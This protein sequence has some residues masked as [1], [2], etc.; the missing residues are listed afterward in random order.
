[1]ALR[2][3]ERIST[4]TGIRSAMNEAHT[5]PDH[6]VVIRPGSSD[7]LDKVKPLWH[8]LYRHQRQHGMELSLP[9]S[10]YADWVASI[11]P[12]LGRFAT[13]MVAEVDAQIIG[14]SAGRVRTMP[15]YF[16][17]V[18]FGLISEVFVSETRRRG[19]TGKRL[20]SA[21]IDWFAAQQITRVELQVVAGNSA[22]IEFY[23]RLGW[24]EELRQMV[25]VRSGIAEREAG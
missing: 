19:G 24:R 11:V 15:P 10:A 9:E 8:A 4:G 18:T 2:R 1:M 3:D 13:V 22:G 20:V 23:A 21:L 14:F 16:G 6:P 25:W 17:S 5:I 7:D 12:F